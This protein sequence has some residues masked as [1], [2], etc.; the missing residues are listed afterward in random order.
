MGTTIQKPRRALMPQSSSW[1]SLE[2]THWQASCAEKGFKQHKKQ[3]DFARNISI[4]VWRRTKQIM[5]LTGVVSKKFDVDYPQLRFRRCYSVSGLVML[6][7]EGHGNSSFK[8]VMI[9]PIYPA[10]VS[11]AHGKG[12]ILAPNGAAIASETFQAAFPTY[13][14]KCLTRSCHNLK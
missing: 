6:H 7:N 11:A 9:A 12:D 10:V 1:I 14:L 3:H 4:R 5:P 8:R 2:S 13:N